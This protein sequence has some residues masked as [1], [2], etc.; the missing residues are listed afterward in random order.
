MWRCHDHKYDPITQ[1]EYY[2]LFAMFQN[3]DE[4]GLYSYFTTSPPTPTLTLTDASRAATLQQLREKVAAHQQSLQHQRASA[5]ARF[6]AWL[7]V[8]DTS[9]LVLLS[10][11]QARFSF[12]EL[13]GN[14]LA[15]SVCLGSAG[16]AQGDNRLVPGRSGQGVQFTGDD[17]VDLPLG[18][19]QR[20]QPFSISLWLKT[21]EAKSRAVVLHRSR[22]WTDAASRGYELLIED[23]RLKWSLIHFWPGNAA[24]VAVRQ[25]VPLDEWLH[26]T[27]SSDGSS[28]ASGLSIHVNGQRAETDVIRDSLT[29]EITGGGGD[30]IAL[31]ERFRDRGFRDGVIDDLR[32]FDVRADGSGM[33][34]GV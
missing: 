31:G 18:N 15:N 32:V 10:G 8:L 19:F 25:P 1:K 29:R 9:R 21:A 17:P 14:Q 24:S 30:N 6:D 3:I 13:Q 22:A 27:V 16:G 12:D 33:S 2:Q 34:C 7:S 23:G 5:A 26:V 20:H 4:A 28:L 11:E